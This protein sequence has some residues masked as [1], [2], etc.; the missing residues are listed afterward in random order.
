MCRDRCDSDQR[1][2]GLFRPLGLLA[3]AAIALEPV[4]ADPKR[5]EPSERARRC[6]SALGDPRH[7]AVWMSLLNTSSGPCSA[8]NDSNAAVATAPSGPRTGNQPNCTPVVRSRWPTRHDLWRRSAP[9]ERHDRSP[10]IFRAVLRMCFDR[11]AVRGAMGPADIRE[12]P[13]GQPSESRATA[14]LLTVK[15]LQE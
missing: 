14:Q 8:N 11:A 6:A 13:A 2:R 1:V 15:E 9:A 7:P 10:E 5:Q 12:V 3:C 4:R